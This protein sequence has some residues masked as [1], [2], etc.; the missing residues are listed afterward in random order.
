MIILVHQVRKIKI[1][2]IYSEVKFSIDVSLKVFLVSLGLGSIH[3]AL[4]RFSAACKKRE[5]AKVV[6]FALLCMKINI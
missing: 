5:K 4:L 6:V 1:C 3:A 2:K